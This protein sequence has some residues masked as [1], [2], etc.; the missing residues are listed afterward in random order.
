VTSQTR[1]RGWLSFLLAFLVFAALGIGV[2]SLAAT[3]AGGSHHR[4]GIGSLATT[5]EPPDRVDDQRPRDII[6]VPVRV[7]RA[8]APIPVVLQV[9][10]AR[11]EAAPRRIVRPQKI[12]ASPGD[13]VPPH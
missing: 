2:R 11:P 13:A 9:S 5:A 6:A 1:Q 8:T 4:G 12:P 3:G 7:R 10:A